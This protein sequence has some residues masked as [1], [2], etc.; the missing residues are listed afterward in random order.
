M[1]KIK[2]VKNKKDLRRFIDFPH[3]LYVNDLNYVPELFIAQRDMLTKGKHP[4]LNHVEFQL[5]LAES[6]DSKVV[7]RIAA[8][9]NLNHNKFANDAN[10]FFG[11]FDCIDNYGVAEELFNA[12]KNWVNNKGLSGLLGPVNYSTNDPCGLLINGFEHLPQIMMTYNKSYYQSIFE[13]YGFQKKMDLFSYWFTPDT[14]PERTIK[15]AK[16]IEQRLSRNG[17]TIRKMNLKKFK[18]EVKGIKKIYNEAWDKKWGFVPFTDDE[19]NYVAKDMKLILDKD[20]VLVAEKNNQMIGFT[21]ALPN[22]NEVQRD[23]KRGR[24]FPTGILK[25]LFNKSKI[26]SI[27]VLTLGVLNDF[28]MLGIEACFYT[29]ITEEA[30]KKGYVGADASWILESNEMM[31]RELKNIGSNVYKVHRLYQLQIR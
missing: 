7:G 8:I 16:N 17:I 9:H 23:V 26:K 20:L 15:L 30:V 5:F 21:L 14:I 22:I 1:I 27:R 24:L 29:K 2:E 4:S 28:R 10:G 18:E 12:A 19:F 31:N 11:F 6:S 25:L 13:R 3:D